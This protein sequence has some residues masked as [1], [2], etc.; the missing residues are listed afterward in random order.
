MKGFKKNGKF[1]PTESKN[2]SALKIS[3]MPQIRRKVDED[4]INKERAEWAWLKR[5]N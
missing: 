2:K 5:D 4:E 1:H 3:D